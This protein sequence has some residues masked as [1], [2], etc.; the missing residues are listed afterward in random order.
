MRAQ[1]LGPAVGRALAAKVSDR[2]RAL[3]LLAIAESI[4]AGKPSP[5]IRELAKRTGLQRE[6]VVAAVDRLE[7]G[8]PLGVFW[9]E[10]DRHNRYLIREARP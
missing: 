5:S 10:G 2:R 9:G 3:V 4:D 8:G 6:E 7:A 1:G